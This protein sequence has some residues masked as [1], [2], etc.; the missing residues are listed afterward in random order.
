MI[1]SKQFD[2]VFPNMTEIGINPN[3]RQATVVTIRPG[4]FGINKDGA[5]FAD[6]PVVFRYKEIEIIAEIPTQEIERLQENNEKLATNMHLFKRVVGRPFQ[7]GH[8]YSVGNKGGRPSKTP[9]TD[10]MREVA[11][12]KYYEVKGSDE[13]VLAIDLMAEQ[14]VDRIVNGDKKALDTFLERIEGRVTQG[15]KLSGGLTHGVP[16]AEEM[17][18]LGEM[19]PDIK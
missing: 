9:L 4:Y 15:I 11:N 7:K 17:A 10:R 13:K 16:T 12:S 14:I 6:Q 18:K 8:R 19:F 5:Q 1:Q 3:T 2:S